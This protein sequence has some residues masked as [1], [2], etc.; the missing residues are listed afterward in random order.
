MAVMEAVSLKRS[1][2]FS[3]WKKLKLLLTKL[4]TK[5]PKLK[6]ESAVATV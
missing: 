4:S 3:L 1:T 6:K 5:D 2:V